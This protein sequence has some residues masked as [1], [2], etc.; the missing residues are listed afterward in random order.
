MDTA[1]LSIVPMLLGPVQTNTYLVADTESRV[2]AV[3]DPAWDGAA[4]VREAERRE[5]RI[6]DIW[7]THAHFDHFAGVG[8]V[9]QKLDPAPRI[10]LHPLDRPLWQRS[11]GTAWF[12]LPTFESGPAPTFELEDGMQLIL[13][14]H[15]FE[16]RHS[17][18]HSPGH[19][20][21]YCAGQACLFSGDLLFA[22]GVGRTDLP[23]GD[24]ETLLASIR[25]RVFNLPDGV[26]VYPGHGPSTTVGRER[27]TNPFLVE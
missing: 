7:L 2:A 15:A 24:W 18:G 21:F 8:G 17:P 23:G 26:Q 27:R 12:G 9:V 14:A 1:P 5:W 22:G 25:E 11:G 16:V 13:G 3:I 10:A 4:I 19:V 6:T 20:M